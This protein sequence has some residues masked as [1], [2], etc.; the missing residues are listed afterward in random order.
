MPMWDRAPR[1]DFVAACTDAVCCPRWPNQPT[2]RARLQLPPRERAA[3]AAS[4]ATRVGRLTRNRA[5]GLGWRSFPVIASKVDHSPLGPCAAPACVDVCFSHGHCSLG[6]PAAKCGIA[7]F[8]PS[9]KPE[10][11]PAVHFGDSR[12]S[13]LRRQSLRRRNDEVLASDSPGNDAEAEGPEAGLAAMQGLELDSYP[14]LHAS[15]ADLLRR[16]GRT[17]EARIAYERALEL[18]AAEPDRRFLARRLAE[19]A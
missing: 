11:A 8:G 15:R 16:L 14:Y 1:L 13:W 5:V 12:S 10:G 9:E 4:R 19:L 3:K 7:A 17:D 6:F 2:E 18:V